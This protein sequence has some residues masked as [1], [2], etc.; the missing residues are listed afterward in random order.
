MDHIYIIKDKNLLMTEV[1]FRQIRIAKLKW[2]NPHLCPNVS[3]KA[4]VRETPQQKPN[5]FF[6]WI[7]QVTGLEKE[8]TIH[9]IH[10]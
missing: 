9:I 1:L 10:T 3:C 7:D 8:L 4:Y 2:R 6:V 5:Q